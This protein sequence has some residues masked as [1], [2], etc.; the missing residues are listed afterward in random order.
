MPQ[1]KRCQAPIQ[2]QK[3]DGRFKMRDHPAGTPHSCAA[4]KTCR[5]CEKPVVWKEHEGKP[6]CFEPDGTTLHNDVCANRD[7]CAH[8]GQKVRWTIVDGKWL[9]LDPVLTRELHWGLCP[10]NPD[11]AKGLVARLARLEAENET[12]K[13]DLA[14]CQREINYR[15]VELRRL[16]QK[17]EGVTR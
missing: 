1:C 4:P 12:L 11:V 16:T 7:E 6:Q 2:W 10:K 9:A 8:C 15:D 13:S 3:E 5:Y 14:K 17:A